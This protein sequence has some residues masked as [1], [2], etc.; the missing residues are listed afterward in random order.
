M[1][2]KPLSFGGLLPFIGCGVRGWVSLIV[3]RC[4]WKFVWF[5]LLIVFCV[6]SSLIIFMNVNF[7]GW[8]VVWFVTIWMDLIL[9]N[10]VKSS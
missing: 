6:S 9:L 4:F 8:F 2:L 5:K 1:L 3:S 10:F 7:C